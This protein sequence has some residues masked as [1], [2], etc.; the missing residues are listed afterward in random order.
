MEGREHC[1]R[2]S[3]P[4]GV[5]IDGLLPLVAPRAGSGCFRNHTRSLQSRGMK[6]VWMKF[7]KKRNEL[8]EQGIHRDKTRTP[9][10]C[11]YIEPTVRGSENRARVGSA[12]IWNSRIRRRLS[13]VVPS[14]NFLESPEIH[15]YRAYQGRAPT[16]YQVLRRTQ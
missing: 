7:V 12:R 4:N 9:D 15:V 6:S 1:A 16:V 11:S 5:G 3:E 2:R 13:T 14:W 10:T 8:T